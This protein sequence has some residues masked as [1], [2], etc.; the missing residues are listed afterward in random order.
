MT[1]KQKEL[2]ITRWV[3]IAGGVVLSHFVKTPIELWGIFIIT[4]VVLLD[5]IIRAQP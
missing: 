2:T 3:I 4:V 1:R 5:T